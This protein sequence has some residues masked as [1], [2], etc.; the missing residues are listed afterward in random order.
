MLILCIASLYIPIYTSMKRLLINKKLEIFSIVRLTSNK[1]LDILSITIK[2]LIAI[3]E[4]K[5]NEKILLKPY[6][7]RPR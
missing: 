5:K 2:H 3:K 7:E 1:T 6:G 4:D